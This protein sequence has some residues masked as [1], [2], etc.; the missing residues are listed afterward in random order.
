[1][2]KTY[3]YDV[4]GKVTSSSGS[5]PNEFDFAAQQTDPT[6]LQYLRARYYDPETGTFLSREPMM[7]APGW[8][9]NPFGYAKVRPTSLV[10]R[11]GLAPT[12]PI[13]NDPCYIDQGPS[14]Q[15]PPPTGDP[16]SNPFNPFLKIYDKV[17]IGATK[18]LI[19]EYGHNA[20]V[21]CV[22]IDACRERGDALFGAYQTNVQV[23]VLLRSFG[24]KVAVLPVISRQVW[25]AYKRQYG[26]GDTP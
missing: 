25:E 11:D 23:A 26:P 24:W 18:L 8:G 19:S 16:G 4:Y 9:G 2:V 21:G 17:L 10:D 1:V 12:P 7:L 22:Q 5:A 14:P 15:C 13:E 20:L 3:G 6:G